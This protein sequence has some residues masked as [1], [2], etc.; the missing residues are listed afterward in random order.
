MPAI[1]NAVRRIA[2][3]RRYSVGGNVAWLGAEGADVLADLEPALAGLG[4]GG[5]VVRGPADR[6]I[7]GDAPVGEFARRV[8][9]VLDPESRFPPL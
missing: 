8:K 6:P 2:P 9:A 1:E 3:L 7:V 5:L 4:V